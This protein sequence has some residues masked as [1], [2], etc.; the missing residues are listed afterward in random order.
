MRQGAG[1]TA[2]RD[3]IVAHA[4]DVHVDHGYTA[5]LFDGDGAGG[6]RAVLEAARGAGADVVLLAGDTFD[7]HRLPDDLIVHT[8]ATMR[9]FDMPI[10]L[11]PGNHDPAIDEAVFH[12]PAFGKVDHLHI[13][14]VTHEEAVVLPHLDLEIWGRAHRDYSDMDPLAAIRERSTPWQIAMAHGHYEPAPDRSTNLRSSWLIGDDEIAA[15]RADYVALGHWNRRVKVGNGHVHAW[16]S[17][18]PDYARSINIVRLSGNGGVDVDRVML[19]LPKD[20]GDG[21]G[22]GFGES[23]A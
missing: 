23:E 21:F 9:A 2:R 17:G 16:Y 3:V 13:L 4:S 7:C 6:L 5:R 12:H 18:S 20:F 14:G 11:L 8:A 10:V 22:D 15:T 1:P 19:E